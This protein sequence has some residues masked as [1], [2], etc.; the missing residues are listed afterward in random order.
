MVYLYN[1]ILLAGESNE[2]LMH[3]I[4]WMD[5]KIILLKGKSQIKKNMYHIITI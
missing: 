2:L 3:A 5:V 1:V 4:T